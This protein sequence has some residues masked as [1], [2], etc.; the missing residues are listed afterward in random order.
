MYIYISSRHIQDMAFIWGGG[1]YLTNMQDISNQRRL[2]VIL[3][4]LYTFSRTY[5]D[6]TKN[7]T[8]LTNM[9]LIKNDYKQS[10]PF[11]SGG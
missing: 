7:F 2:E 3:L 11:P 4:I 9:K 8:D 6:L 10:K 1:L 5:D